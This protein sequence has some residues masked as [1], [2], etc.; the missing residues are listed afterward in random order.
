MPMPKTILSALIVI[1]TVISGGSLSAQTASAAVDSTDSGMRV[2]M[3]TDTLA[4][5]KTFGTDET[6][7][8]KSYA[9]KKSPTKAL[10]YSL[11][12]GMGQV[13]VES[14]WKAPFFAGAAGFLVYNIVHYNRL[15]E[16]TKLVILDLERDGADISDITA[17][18]NTREFHRDNRDQSAFWLMAVYAISAIDAYVGAH[19][20]DFNVDDNLSLNYYPDQ[21]RGTVVSLSIDF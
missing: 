9:M 5:D 13:Y 4:G 12:P 7:L 18:K 21:M 6:I 15:F 19:L 1:I 14:Y 20:Y 2:I 8:S 11:I 3:P 17:A 10:I 16:E